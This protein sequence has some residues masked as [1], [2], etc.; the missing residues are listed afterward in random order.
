MVRLILERK[1]L[2]FTWQFICEILVYVISRHNF[3]F[4]LWNKP[5]LTFSPGK[6]SF[7]N[8]TSFVL[9]HKNHQNGT[10]LS[11][12]FWF[13]RKIIYRSIPTRHPDFEIILIVFRVDIIPIE[14]VFYIPLYTIHTIHDMKIRCVIKC[15]RWM[16]SDKNFTFITMRYSLRKKHRIRI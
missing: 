5:K 8:S 16:T 12:V 6:N 7:F 9:K 3:Q 14:N 13:L 2:Y 1:L 10:K 11:H 15:S 4:K